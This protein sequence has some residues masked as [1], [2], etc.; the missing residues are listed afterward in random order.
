MAAPIVPIEINQGA[1][2]K[3]RLRIRNKDTGAPISIAGYKFCGAIV[4]TVYDDV[5]YEFEFFVE[6]EQNGVVIATLKDTVSETIDFVDGH[7]DIEFVIG[8]DKYRVIQGP[9]T[10]SLGGNS[11][12]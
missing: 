12:C 1:T 2:F 8:G 3:M 9:V 4:Q 11:K 6:D 7:Y 5:T 10:V